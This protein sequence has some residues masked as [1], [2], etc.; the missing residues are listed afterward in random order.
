MIIFYVLSEMLAAVNW[1]YVA[2]G[3]IFIVVLAGPGLSRRRHKRQADP[4]F[5][6]RDPYVIDGDTLAAGDT[7]IRIYGMDAPES[8]HPQGAASTRHM[9]SLVKGRVLSVIPLETDV[10]GRLV[11]RVRVGGEDL[12]ARMVRDGYAMV[13]G[14][15]RREY[16]RLE[17]QA[18][19]A[20]LGL[21]RN[22]RIHDP[23]EWRDRQA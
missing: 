6:V 23:K 1:S 15:S 8:D 17:K 10:Y 12:A 7:R 2:G 13:P 9:V 4:A 16:G 3:V 14:P 5:R 21:W 19:K 22:G 18:R 11:A 20:H